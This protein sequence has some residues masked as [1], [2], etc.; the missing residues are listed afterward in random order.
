MPLWQQLHVEAQQGV[1]A[2]LQ[3]DAGQQHVHRSRRLSVGIWQPGVQGHD[4]QLHPKGDQQ[5]CVG[6]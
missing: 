1:A 5:A 2:H 3:Q 4:R 6:E